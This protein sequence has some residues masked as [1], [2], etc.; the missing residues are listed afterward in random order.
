MIQNIIKDILQ[1]FGQCNICKLY[2][3]IFSALVGMGFN[4]TKGL[5]WILLFN[6]TDFV[7]NFL[8]YFYHEYYIYHA[9][10]VQNNF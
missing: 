5:L 9:Y 4:I 8:R 1:Y 10:Y 7:L 6:E 2:I 3:N